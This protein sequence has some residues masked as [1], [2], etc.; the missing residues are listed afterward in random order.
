QKIG[1]LKRNGK[2]VRVSYVHDY[3]HRPRE[4]DGMSLYDWISTYKRGKLPAKKK[5]KSAQTGTLDDEAVEKSDCEEDV[6]VVRDE[7]SDDSD[8]GDDRTT[9]TAKGMLRFTTDDPLFATHGLK[10][11]SSP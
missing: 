3:V 6:Q 7:P 8:D 2:I 10:H 11:L 4:L 1:M 5:M 9:T